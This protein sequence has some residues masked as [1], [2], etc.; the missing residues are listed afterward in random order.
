MN[1]VNKWL[2][3]ALFLKRFREPIATYSVSLANISVDRADF[4]G[5]ASVEKP[6]VQG[7]KSVCRI[8]GNK[9]HAVHVRWFFETCF[10]AAVNSNF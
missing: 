4:F 9:A 5:K 6:I 7:K 8:A 10:S 3:N 1:R 2:L